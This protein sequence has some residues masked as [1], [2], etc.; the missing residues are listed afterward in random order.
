MGSL[1]LSEE[2]MG[3]GW[4]EG[5]GKMEEGMKKEIGLVCKMRKESF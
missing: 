4:I 2:G 1:T 3:L 5:R